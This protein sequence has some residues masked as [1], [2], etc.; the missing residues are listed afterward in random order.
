MKNVLFFQRKAFQRKAKAKKGFFCLTRKEV[1]DINT[2]RI[3]EFN[4]VQINHF[5]VD[6]FNELF[7]IKP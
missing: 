1:K 5:S 6:L 3:K 2:P 7:G 4:S